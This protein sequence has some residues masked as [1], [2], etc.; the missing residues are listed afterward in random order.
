M[1]YINYQ[2]TI[3]IQRK[4]GDQITSYNCIISA[5]SATDALDKLHTMCDGGACYNYQVTKLNCV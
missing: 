5:S 1:R 2:A 3:T 4:E